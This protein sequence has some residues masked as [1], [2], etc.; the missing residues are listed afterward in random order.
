MP[1]LSSTYFPA[2][3]PE[4]SMCLSSFVMDAQQAPLRFS[5]DVFDALETPKEIPAE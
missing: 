3:N 4:Q 2:S 5:A 1:A